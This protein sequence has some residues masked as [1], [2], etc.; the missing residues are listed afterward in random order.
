M[1]AVVL[2]SVG[3]DIGCGPISARARVYGGSFTAEQA[4]QLHDA[5]DRASLTLPISERHRF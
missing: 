1:L 2:L 5:K 3:H 4:A